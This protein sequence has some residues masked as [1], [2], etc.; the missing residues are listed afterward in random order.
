MRIREV[1]GDMDPA[2]ARRV[3]EEG[4]RILA[5]II[6]RAH[7]RSLGLLPGSQDGPSASSSPGGP[8]TAEGPGVETSRRGAGG[9]TGKARRR[10]RRGSGGGA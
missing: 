8:N 7:L 2:E 6:A 4:L 10:S 9:R 5:R 1:P 3:V